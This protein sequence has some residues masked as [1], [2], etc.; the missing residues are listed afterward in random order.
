MEKFLI[1]LILLAAFNCSI[2]QAVEMISMKKIM[3]SNDQDKKNALLRSIAVSLWKKWDEKA[4]KGM[5][6]DFPETKALIDAVKELGNDNAQQRITAIRLLSDKVQAT[7][8]VLDFATG[9]D[10]VVAAEALSIIRE[11]HMVEAIPK[12]KKR[13]QDQIGVVAGGGAELQAIRSAYLK[14]LWRTYLSLTNN[15][16]EDWE[17]VPDGEVLVRLF[18]KRDE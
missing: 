18:E 6:R 2:A 17:K 5:I 4:A 10:L 14:S 15:I 9:H 12:I 1:H 8:I 3:E 11:Q 13:L 7:E 16:E